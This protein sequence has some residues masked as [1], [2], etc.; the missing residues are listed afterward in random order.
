MDI[1]KT[2]NKIIKYISKLQLYSNSF[3]PYKEALKKLREFQDFD[4]TQIE[5]L[6]CLCLDIIITCN[7]FI[8]MKSD[9]IN[10]NEINLYINKINKCINI[11]EL[12]NLDR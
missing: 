4:K 8:R 10:C 5:Y 11:F 12:H 6:K 2:F 1:Q 9:E 7:T 3:N